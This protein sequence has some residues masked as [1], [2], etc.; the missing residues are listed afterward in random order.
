MQE[1]LE[2]TE[3]LGLAG[4]LEE[5]TS[6]TYLGKWHLLVSSTNWE[7][8]RIIHQWRLALI[9]AQASPLQFSDEAWSRR[10]GNV[11]SQHVGRL[12]RVFDRFGAVRESYS[13]LYWSHF[14]AAI[15]WNDAE[16][17]LEGAVQNGWSVAEMRTSRWM[18]MGS[19]VEESPQ[20][21]DVVAAEMD[22]DVVAEVTTEIKDP[23]ARETTGPDLS[24]GPDFGDEGYEGDGASAYD[25]GES[26]SGEL[27][28]G[29]E[30][31]GPAPESARPF[32]NLAALPP[33]LAD[34]MESFKLAILRHKLSGWAEV[35]AE[36]VLEALNGLRHLVMTAS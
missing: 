5:E 20:E 18:A 28:A 26:A 11:S 36:D 34:A 32:E 17:W 8:G 4:A 35:S 9:E 12:R 24:E 14:Q 30:D 16:M 27:T 2:S 1:S 15:D 21:T 25:D 10:V 6:L 31:M 29:V 33:D 19:P 3:P 23:A 13:G 7:K 22:E